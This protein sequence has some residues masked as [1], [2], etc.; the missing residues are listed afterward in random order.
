VQLPPNTP[1]DQGGADQ[2]AVD[3]GAADQDGAE[4]AAAMVT[5]MLE[6]QQFSEAERIIFWGLSR[7]APNQGPDG[8]PLTFEQQVSMTMDKARKFHAAQRSELMQEFNL[9]LER[10][11]SFTGPAQGGAQPGAVVSLSLDDA[12][13]EADRGR[14]LA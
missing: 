4:Q 5:G 13:A 11:G 9:P 10:G 8:T 14:T 7:S 3:Q 1:A 2:G 6:S 12:I